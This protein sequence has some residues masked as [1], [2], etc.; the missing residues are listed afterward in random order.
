MYMTQDSDKSPKKSTSKKKTSGSSN[1][2]KKV[3]EGSFI[4]GD[5]EFAA[6]IRKA[7]ETNLDEY[8][9]KRNL[10]KKQITT[11]T[12][13]IEEHLSCFV[14]LGYTVD[15]EPITIVNANTPKDSDSLGTA[16]QKFLAR[17]SD[18][19]PPIGLF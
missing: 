15:G 10:T 17:Y 2:E 12:S 14:L 9:K 16:L 8:S 6:K 4:D 19:P 11:I 13:F 3:D 5:E 18:P 1:K 7:L